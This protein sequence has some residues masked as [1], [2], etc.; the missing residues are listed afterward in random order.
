MPEHDLQEHAGAHGPEHTRGL[1]T[2]ATFNR[3]HGPAKSDGAHG[4]GEPTSVRKKARGGI[5]KRKSRSRSRTA[6]VS[7]CHVF[8]RFALLFAAA[9]SGAAEHLGEPLFESPIWPCA[10]FSI[11][12]CQP[13]PEFL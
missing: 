7:A 8:V 4:H 2:C 12:I 5:N 11:P 13:P 3:R 6:A 10:S 9:G 1:A